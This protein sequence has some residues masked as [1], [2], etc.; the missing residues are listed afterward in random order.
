MTGAVGLASD[1][2]RI[3]RAYVSECREASGGSY[4]AWLELAPD[5]QAVN[6]AAAQAL[7]DAG[8]IAPGPFL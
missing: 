2:E 3:A 1:A 6:I 7:L 5:M 8:I 4:R